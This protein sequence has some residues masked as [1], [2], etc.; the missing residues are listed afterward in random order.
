MTNETIRLTTDVDP[1]STDSITVDSSADSTSR[2]RRIP[3]HSLWIA[4]TII[5][6]VTYAWE[7]L[8]DIGTGLLYLAADRV[9][10][11]NP[12]QALTLLDYAEWLAP[13]AA[14]VYSKRGYIH[15]QSAS[16]NTTQDP[17]ATNSIAI[18]AFEEALLF[19]EREASALNNL[20]RLRADA[21]EADRAVRLQGL[22]AIYEPNNATVHHNHG[23]L[24][25]AR[26]D[27]IGAA[28]AF[29]EAVRINPGQITSHLYLSLSYLQ[30]NALAKAEFAARQALLLDAR[31]PDAH[32]ALIRARYY[33]R[34]WPAA[35]AAADEASQLFP[36]E[37]T[38]PLFKALLLRE[39]GDIAGARALVDP[40]VATTSDERVVRMAT[41]ILNVVQ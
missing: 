25:L 1:T 38:F 14:Y 4:L 28:R 34:Q 9:Q 17:P 36:D 27:A 6:V 35:F 16:D 10:T 2:L 19:S 32:H 29:Q 23:L 24:L 20:A 41:E 39:M 8:L 22:A 12:A 33:Q 31:E 5:G 15:V 30:Q 11:S 3:W 40:I 7:D 26:G 18:D 21:G 13:D 37:V